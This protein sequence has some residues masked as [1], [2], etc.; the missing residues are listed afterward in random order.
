MGTVG[1]C[2]NRPGNI[3]GKMLAR[4]LYIVI[5][6]MLAG[7]TV[8]AA[9]LP[10]Q[11]FSK[12]AYLM[13]VQFRIDLYADN[14]AIADEAF[15]AGFA[16]IDELEQCLS[17]YRADS[18]LSLLCRSTG[19]V[20]VSD[21][22]WKVLIYAEQISRLSHGAFDVTVGRVTKLWRRARRQQQ[23][24]SAERLQQEME[25]VGFDKLVLDRLAKT[26]TIQKPGLLIDLGA[27]GKGYAAD[28]ALQVL[29]ELGIR[30]AVVDASGDVRFGAAP[31]GKSGWATG[32]AALSEGGTPIL[33]QHQSHGA[34]ATSGD[35]F[36]FLEF[37]GKRYSHILDPRTGMPVQVRSSVSIHAATGMQADALAS[38]V[39]VMGPRRGIR[40]V[41]RLDDVEVMVIWDRDG[42]GVGTIHQTRG[43]PRADPP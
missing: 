34:V 43:F 18:E 28:E 6:L 5:L 8:P 11:R 39:S 26:V 41:R 7:I 37:Q 20:R 36:Q 38:A 25:F 32:I 29:A 12:T 14:E 35:A 31:P 40:L 22:L 21:D 13:G 3:S 15:T 24:P 42:D 33:L 16:R 23:I 19:P 2:E 9:E 1:L 27:I 30:S 10:P 17:N 4:T